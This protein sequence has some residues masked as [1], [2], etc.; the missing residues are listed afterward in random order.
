MKKGV[1]RVIVELDS[2]AVIDTMHNVNLGVDGLATLVH[3]CLSLALR[4]PHI[5]FVHTPRKGNQYADFLAN[6]GQGTS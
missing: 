3:D 2:K 5:S 6:L 4:V 1:S